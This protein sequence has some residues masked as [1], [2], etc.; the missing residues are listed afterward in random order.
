MNSDEWASGAPDRGHAGAGSPQVEIEEVAAAG[1]SPRPPSPGRRRR[2]P[3]GPG[4]AVRAGLLVGGLAV[5]IVGVGL[6]GDRP[7][8]PPEAASPSPVVDAV[9]RTASP[10]VAVTAPA[11][12]PLLRRSGEPLADPHVLVAGRWMDVGSGRAVD[13]APDGC[14]GRRIHVLGSGRVVCVTS[15]ATRT[16]GSR[17]ALYDLG[18]TTVGSVRVDPTAPAAARAPAGGAEPQALATLLGR[19]DVVIGDPVAI[20]MSPGPGADDLV[21]AWA[22]A[23]DGGYEI[24]LEAFRLADAGGQAERIGDWIVGRASGTGRDA[25]DTLADLAVAVDAGGRALVGWT[26]SGPGVAGP[27]RRLVA[28]RLDGSARPTALPAASTRNL[29]PDAADGPLRTGTPC[30]GGF[31]EGLSGDGTA[32]VVCPG[33]TATLRVLDLGSG[34]SWDATDWGAG[35]G[36]GRTTGRPGLVLAEV[37]L[38]AAGSTEGTAW[39]AGNGVAVDAS[40]STLYR[41]SPAV[42]T[43]WR[44]ELGSAD[45]GAPRVT[46]VGLLPRRGALET[47][48]TGDA[49][50]SVAPRPTLAL[51]PARGRLYALDA[52]VPKTAGRAVVHVIDTAGMRYLWSFPLADAGSRAVSLSPD[53]RFLYASTEPRQAGGPSRVVGLAV[54]DAQTGIEIAYAGRLRVDARAPLQAVVVR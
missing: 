31:G 12:I 38:D 21:L 26:E 36:A 19:R 49:G 29:A 10:D 6:L 23:G 43:I 45:G 48:V 52:P 13:G 41:W 50:D 8:A 44:V 5:A 24:G 3:A 15:D 46:S 35:A 37:P 32:W 14:A 42:G 53:G 11:P 16:P 18:V 30:G 39:L 4:P 54:L 33:T 40:T 1:R 47:G 27:V 28:V 9:E 2:R 7:P 34:P 22:A 20:A 17:I 51:D 25:V